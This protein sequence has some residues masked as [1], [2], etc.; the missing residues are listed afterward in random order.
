MS[1]RAVA[2][3]AGVSASF[4]SQFERGATNASVSSLRGMAEVVGIPLADLFDDSALFRPKVLRADER[5]RLTAPG[6]LSKYLVSLHPL[7]NLEV[8]MGEFEPG[9]STGDPYIHNDAQEIFIVLCGTVL[10]ELGGTAHVLNAGDSIAFRSS[11]PHAM[12]NIGTVVAET[13]WIS[14]PPPEPSLAE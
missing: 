14:S 6:G 11:T 4:I 2:E 1:L 13:M 9:A 7:E 10:A 8:Y 3:R 12:Q 5:P